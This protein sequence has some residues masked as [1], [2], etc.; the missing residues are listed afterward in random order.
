MYH[1]FMYSAGVP[2]IQLANLE[3]DK[4]TCLLPDEEL[5]NR[6]SVASHQKPLH[7]TEVI[8]LDGSNSTCLAPFDEGHRLLQLYF[9][10]TAPIDTSTDFVLRLVVKELS[11]HPTDIVVTVNL[12]SVQCPLVESFNERFSGFRV[13]SYACPLCLWCGGR[14]MGFTVRLE[15]LVGGPKNY[16]RTRICSIF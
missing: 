15:R 7:N 13:C 16:T 1:T 4:P 6:S 5:L 3:H 11:C 2:H 10:V 14:K 8:L 9:L 12:Q